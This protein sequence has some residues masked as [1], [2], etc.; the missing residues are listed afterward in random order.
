ML[1]CSPL[2]MLWAAAL[3]AGCRTVTDFDRQSGAFIATDSAAYAV[4]VEGGLYH[5]A[6]GYTYTNGTHAP[7]S[8]D[9]CHVPGPPT[10]EKQVGDQWVVA[11]HAIVLLC[12]TVPPFRIPG[13]SMYRG[14]LGLAVAP[15][16]ANMGP[17]LLVDSIPGTYR[18]RWVLRA[19]NDPQDKAAPN[20][21][22]ISN[23]FRL[24]ER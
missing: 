16:G 1:R 23:S 11:Y 20:V 19:G 9:Y 22:A 5:A 2:L 10:L 14:T 21:E 13:G 18:L 4:H 24:F 17:P 12:Q 3:A 15:G 8:A 6:I 7:V